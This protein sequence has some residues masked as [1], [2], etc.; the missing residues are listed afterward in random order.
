[1]EGKSFDWDQHE[2]LL[3]KTMK[4]CN[5]KQGPVVV[6]SPNTAVLPVRR[7]RSDKHD[8]L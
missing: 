5:N 8:A 3:F 1:M 4:T 2:R 7:R 6:N